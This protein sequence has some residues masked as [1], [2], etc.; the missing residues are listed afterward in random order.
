[1]TYF[2]ILP[3]CNLENLELALNDIYFKFS[4]SISKQLNSLAMGNALSPA[5]ANI[6]VNSFKT[7]Y[8]SECSPEYQPFY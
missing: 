6:F 5:I 1:M 7:K 2:T 3:D 4:G 8:V